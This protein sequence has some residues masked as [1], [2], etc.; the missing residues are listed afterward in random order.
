[1]EVKKRVV[2]ELKEDYD[3]FDN[4]K[5]GN[6]SLYTDEA[7]R[8]EIKGDTLYSYAGRTDDRETMEGDGEV[9]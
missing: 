8:K 4:A 6:L 2:N 9:A 3:G 1:M 7:R 5:S